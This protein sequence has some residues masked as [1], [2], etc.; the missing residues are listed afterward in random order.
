[1]TVEEF[2]GRL[3]RV[4]RTGARLGRA[5][6][7]PRGRHA[8]LS[9]GEGDDG[10]VLLN[11]SPAARPEEVV[12]ALGLTMA[13]LFADTRTTPGDTRATVQHRSANP[14]SSTDSGVAGAATAKR[15]CCTVATGSGGVARVHARGVRRGEGSAGRLPPLARSLGLRSTRTR[16]PCGC[17]T[18]TVTATSRR[19]AS[20]S[21]STA[22]TSSAG[23]NARSS[24]CTG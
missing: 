12:A 14:H 5:L 3:E 18:S 22:R 4:K 11:A 9:I 23:S 6:P 10:R 8:S 24:A 17:R 19:S 21:R 15:D 2:L 7:A 16:R 1:M 13:D 20:A